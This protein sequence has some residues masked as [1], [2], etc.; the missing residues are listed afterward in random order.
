MRYRY[1][2]WTAKIAEKR[3]HS[4]K[5]WSDSISSSFSKKEEL[6]IPSS[7]FRSC[8]VCYRYI[9]QSRYYSNARVRD[10]ERETIEARASASRV[11]GTS[12]EP[13]VDTYCLQRTFTRTKYSLR[14]I[15]D[16]S[17][18]GRY[19]ARLRS[20]LIRVYATSLALFRR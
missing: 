5:F 1:K 15:D 12:Y 7:L 18:Y 19:D 9:T 10:E 6:S 2:H 4:N 17:T 20:R 8:R 11:T 16:R 13:V 3:K 14:F